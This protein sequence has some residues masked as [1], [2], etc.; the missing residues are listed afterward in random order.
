LEQEN[1]KQ[2]MKSLKQLLS[3]Y[4]Q[5]S[6]IVESNLPQIK[7]NVNQIFIIDAMNLFIRNFSVS[8]ILD[9]RGNHI[10]GLVGRFK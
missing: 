9:K 1:F 2:K 5:N 8:T 4:K 3:E 6:P 10:G 7:S